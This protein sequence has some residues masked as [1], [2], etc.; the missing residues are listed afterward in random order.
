LDHDSV[1]AASPADETG[2]THHASSNVTGALALSALTAVAAVA[3]GTLGSSSASTDVRTLG[4]SNISGPAPPGQ[5]SATASL[6]AD[7]ALRR[8]QKA[9]PLDIEES[10]HA[11]Q[12]PTTASSDTIV[13]E[14]KDCFGA[15]S[16]DRLRQQLEQSRARMHAKGASG[17]NAGISNAADS[18]DVLAEASVISASLASA[19][20]TQEAQNIASSTLGPA[21]SDDIRRTL[22]WVRTLTFPKNIWL[23]SEH[24]QTY[25]TN[26]FCHPQYRANK[27]LHAL[28]CGGGGDCL[29][30]SFA[31]ALGRMVF[32]DDL[33]AKHILR[34]LPLHFSRKGNPR[35]CENYAG[36][37][38][39]LSLLGRQKCSW[40][41]SYVHVW[42]RSWEVLK[43]SGTHNKSWHQLVSNVSSVVKVSWPLAWSLTEMLL[44]ASRTLM[45]VQE[46]EIVA[47]RS[48]FLKAAR[49]IC[50]RYVRRSKSSSVDLGIATGAHSL[51]L[52]V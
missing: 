23:P 19:S 21:V 29:F 3:V 33:A 40:I 49:R 50:A 36:C 22:A 44:S 35:S 45:L 46:A 15:Q 32:E 10:R 48:F 20:S 43:M 42:M 6:C 24:L 34:R 52:R 7:A 38:P 26:H 51:M 8:S 31:G 28:E 30:Y 12:P 47:K 2:E 37:P 11:S 17:S 18:S 9:A 16:R 1:D 4:S 5:G 13:D 27:Y 41:T 14:V 25:V 39:T